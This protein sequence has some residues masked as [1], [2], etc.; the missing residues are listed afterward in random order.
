M[1]KS[2]SQNQKSF[3]NWHKKYGR[4]GICELPKLRLLEEENI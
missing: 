3:F 2:K 1:K 4:F